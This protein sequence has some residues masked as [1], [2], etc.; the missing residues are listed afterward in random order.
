M[1]ELRSLTALAEDVEFARDMQS[2]ALQLADM[3]DAYDGLVLE[4][5]DLQ[6]DQRKATF[7][8]DFV[9]VLH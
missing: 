6:I 5:L 8:I 7:E 1:C 3:R 4:V 2:P 9:R